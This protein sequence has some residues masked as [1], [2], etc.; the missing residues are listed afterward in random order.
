MKFLLCVQEV[1][2]WF[3]RLLEGVPREVEKTIEIETTIQGKNRNCF[4]RVGA[5]VGWRIVK[6]VL[7]MNDTE[8]RFDETPNLS[9]RD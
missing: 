2:S 6:I 5:E 1:E 3:E 4:F 7:S 8:A 9:V